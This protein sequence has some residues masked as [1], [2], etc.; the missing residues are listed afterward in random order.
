MTTN[1]VICINN[2]GVEDE[3]DVCEVREISEAIINPIT[4]LMNFK[5]SESGKFLDSKRFKLFMFSPN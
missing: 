5:V 3:I 4:G 1:F 2:S